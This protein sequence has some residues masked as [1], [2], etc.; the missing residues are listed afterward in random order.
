MTKRYL[1]NWCVWIGLATGVYSAIYL[2]TPLKNY[3]V[4]YATFIAL[5][6]Y[7]ISGAKREE[8]FNFTISNITGV[9]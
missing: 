9:A 6:I 3:G 7:F 8:Y 4:I 1:F 2:L 5:P